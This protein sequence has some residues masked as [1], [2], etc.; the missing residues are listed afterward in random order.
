M[1]IRWPV[2]TEQAASR[3]D[4]L[5]VIGHVTNGSSPI[6]HNISSDVSWKPLVNFPAKIL[7]IVYGFL[8]KLLIRQ[9]SP[10]LNPSRSQVLHRNPVFICIRHGESCLRMFVYLPLVVTSFVGLSFW[11]L[12]SNVTNSTLRLLFSTFP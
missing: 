12:S 6:W 8:G 11:I 3:Y 5:I 9:F 1:R 2:S 10:M 7:P 4:L